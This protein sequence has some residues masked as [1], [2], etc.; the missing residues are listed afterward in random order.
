[1]IANMLT[2]LGDEVLVR[3]L[4]TLLAN[5]R[6]TT[7]RIVAYLAEIDARRLYV[8]AG[9]PSMYEFCIGELGM[10]EDA[11]CNRLE[12]ARRCREF[13]I[14][15]DALA[16]GR[17][18][19]SAVREIGPHLTHA[20]AESVIAQV[21][22]LRIRELRLLIARRFPRGEAMRLDDGVIA[23]G[24][25]S[26]APA[27]VPSPDSSA[28]TDLSVTSRI[29]PPARKSLNPLSPNRFALEITISGETETRLR[30]FQSLVGGH[31]DLAQ[32]I[33]RALVIA[34]AR[35]EKRK[36]A[37]TSRPRRARTSNPSPRSIPAA[38]QRAAW[39]RDEGRCT[40][41]GPN[42]HRCTAGGAAVEFDHLVPVALGGRATLD[43][44]RLLCRAHNQ[45]EAERLLGKDFMEG[46]RR[47]AREQRERD[48]EQRLDVIAALKKLGMR[49]TEAK[50]AADRA[51][52]EP[53]TSLEERIKAAL[54]RPGVQRAPLKQPAAAI[55]APAV[56]P[57]PDLVAV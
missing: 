55:P 31:R 8:P 48:E 40:F 9:Y 46:K 41:V 52:R 32:V 37:A 28:A 38:V 57:E 16:D 13:P 39:G 36:F 35:V 33:D 42:G 10:S 5:D 19:L 47:Q 43:N 22:H 12:V 23:L 25:P 6:A 34:I 54:R 11:A 17:L 56:N 51:M 24:A 15:F 27:T 2:H 45:Y 14:L 21:T 1:M 53:C 49:A 26:G 4:R 29:D 3:D 50:E 30:H 7:A 18:G 20:N 44:V